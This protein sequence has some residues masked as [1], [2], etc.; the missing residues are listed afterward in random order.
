MALTARKSAAGPDNSAS[1]I[2]TDDHV[3][4]DATEVT[5]LL[6]AGTRR[7]QHGAAWEGLI[8]DFEGL[9]WWERPSV[10]WLMGPFALFTLAFGGCIVPK[11]NLI[12][13]LV[14]V[15]YL[16]E[17]QALPFAVTSPPG[18]LGEKDPQCLD[19]AVQKNVATF[20]LVLNLI[21][22]VLS[23]LTAPKYGSLSDRYGRKTLMALCSVGGLFGEVITILAAKFPDT[24]HYNWLLVGAFFDGLTGSYTAGSILTHSYASDC[25]APSTRSVAYG[26][27]HACLYFGLAFGPLLAAYLVEKTGALISIFYVALGCHLFWIFFVAFILPESL[28]KRRQKAAREKFA[29]ERVPPA[30]PRAVAAVAVYLPFGGKAFSEALASLATANPFAPLHVLVPKSRPRVGRNMLTLALID[31]GILAATMSS[32]TVTLL[33]V[34]Y[35]FG[36]RTAETSRYVSLMSLVRVTVLVGLLPL[37]NYLFRTLP[38]RRAARRQQKPQIATATATAVVPAEKNAGADALDIWLLRVALVSDIVGVMGYVFARSA[39]VFVACGVVTA[40]GGLASATI[41]AALTKHVPAE[42]VGQV[43]GAI[44][45]LHALSRI[46]APLVFNGLYA[47]TIEVF[48]QAFFVLLAVMF[49]VCCGASLL[50]RPHVFMREGE[51]DEEEPVPPTALPRSNSAVQNALADEDFTPQ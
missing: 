1:G 6:G 4:P 5:A 24:I 42:R 26:Y 13:N 8:D 39:A 48:P 49:A 46:M 16:S 17:R 31:T 41:Q 7:D 44:G 11:L 10:Y 22:G 9:P 51:E 12:I 36:W 50:V 43:L 27:L 30:V 38:A 23:G 2:S 37:I 40:L 3:A 45:L 21:L 29:S 25:T 34:E 47:A 14:C 35:M 32:S 15:R 18:T 28:S 33:Y 20:M 19:P